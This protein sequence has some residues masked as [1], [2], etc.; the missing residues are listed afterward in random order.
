MLATRPPG[1]RYLLALAALAAA[2][3]CSDRTHVTNP[4]VP[5][6][7]SRTGAAPPNGGKIRVKQFQLSSNT[8]NIDGPAVSGNVSIG[9]SGA[10]IDNVALRGEI[11]Q[12]TVSHAA[13]T[14]QLTCAGNPGTLP[15][16][17]CTMT[18]TAA[19]SNSPGDAAT[20]VPGAA[21]F[22]LDVVQDPAGAATV[23][24][25]KSLNVNLVGAVA[26]TSLTL[27]STTLAIG[28]T[29]V[30]WTATLNNP[31]GS[32]N[33][34]TLQGEFLQPG[35]ERAAG[36]LAVVC[37]SAAGVL[38]PGTCTASFIATAS[39]SLGGSGT[40]TPGAATF[41][42]QLIETNGGTS[43]VLDTKTVDVTLVTNT[44]RIDEV[45]LSSTYLVVDGPSMDFTVAVTN[46]T[47]NTISNAWVQLNLIQGGVVRVSLSEIVECGAGDGV[48]T[49]GTCSV[50]G[51]FSLYSYFEGL[52]LGDATL[53]VRL[54]QSGSTSIDYDSKPFAVSVV[55]NTPSIA[56]WELAS[57]TIPIESGVDYTVTLFNPT[58]APLSVAVVQA[59]IFQG[60][61][62]KAAGGANVSCNSP[63]DGTMPV[64][65]CTFQ[66]HAVISNSA[67]T[68][69][70]VAGPATLRLRLKLFDSASQTTT[71]LDEKSVSVTLTTP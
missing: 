58:S 60:T 37:G 63:L 26:I 10:P 55:P 50:S 31:G 39:N 57:T 62:Q 8:L 35:V 9:N 67:G 4:L 52:S 25:S 68:G 49:P 38:P 66:W 23:L 29:G 54:F 2:A 16:G 42:L 41:R 27:Q 20:L 21:V 14:V 24:A 7:A 15:N 1:R 61:T 28:G 5:G 34:V 46:P 33:N 6:A 44:P 11:V 3:A 56:K 70:L 53:Q 22:V 69:T 71:T 45:T 65:A 48:F 43:T 13:L 47:T 36:G 64:G 19:A 40:L 12:G 17:T 18:F 51:H 59:D 32:L 30:D